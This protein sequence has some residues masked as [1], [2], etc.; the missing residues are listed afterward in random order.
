MLVIP[1]FLCSWWGFAHDDEL[2]SR[3]LLRL[4]RAHLR[5]AHA[6]SVV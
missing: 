1:C 2:G 4:L 5:K 3:D 6:Q